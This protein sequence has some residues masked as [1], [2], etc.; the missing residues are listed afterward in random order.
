LTE[1]VQLQ[2][3]L[4]DSYTIQRELGGGGMSRVFVARENA[5][6]RPCGR[7]P[8]LCFSRGWPRPGAALAGLMAEPTP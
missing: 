4:G 2:R 1:P 8:T 6:D 7:M 5:L 3:A